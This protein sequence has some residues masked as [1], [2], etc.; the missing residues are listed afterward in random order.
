M[1][2]LEGVLFTPV[3][4]MSMIK[5]TAGHAEAFAPVEQ[6]IAYVRNLHTQGHSRIVVASARPEAQRRAV[7]A[8]LEQHRVPFHALLLGQ[9]A[10]TT[11]VVSAY[12]NG[13]PHPSSASYC[14]PSGAG[15]LGSLLHL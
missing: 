9:M 2:L 10:S 6:N 4:G 8:L 1:L 12:G 15:Q 11:F 3:L 14:L 13:Q 5:V 7:E